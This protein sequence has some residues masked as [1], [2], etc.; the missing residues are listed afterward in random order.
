MMVG[1]RKLCPAHRNGMVNLILVVGMREFHTG[2]LSYECHSIN[3]DTLKQHGE[4]NR[5]WYVSLK[6][7]GKLNIWWWV[8]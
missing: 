2:S 6:Q 1:R 3:K 7:Y 5:K 8:E 4:L